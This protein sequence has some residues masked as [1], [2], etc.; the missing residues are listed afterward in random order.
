MQAK[1]EISYVQYLISLSISDLKS[2]IGVIVKDTT[3]SR[4]WYDSGW[5]CHCCA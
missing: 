2:V 1:Y 5:D 4:K 3:V